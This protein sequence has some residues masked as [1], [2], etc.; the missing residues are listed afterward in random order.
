M[1]LAK[2]LLLE[3]PKS[4]VWVERGRSNASLHSQDQFPN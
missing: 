2:R 4:W 3:T 1:Y